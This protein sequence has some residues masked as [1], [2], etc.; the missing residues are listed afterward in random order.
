M[1]LKLGSRWPGKNLNTLRYA[2]DNHING[3]KQRGI[4]QLLEEGERGE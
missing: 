3:K 4:K 1:K 2:D